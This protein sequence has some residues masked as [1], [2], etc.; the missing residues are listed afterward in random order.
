MNHHRRQS[1]FTWRPHGNVPLWKWSSDSTRALCPPG[2][3]WQ[4]GNQPCSKAAA[5]PDCSSSGRPTKRQGSSRGHAES[6][7]RG[8][9]LFLRPCRLC[10]AACPL[11]RSA[12]GT[13]IPRTP[14]EHPTLSSRDAQPRSPFPTLGSCKAPL[15]GAEPRPAPF[16]IYGLGLGFYFFFFLSPFPSSSP[17][18]LASFPRAAPGGGRKGG[19]GDGAASRGDAV[20]PRDPPRPAWSPPGHGEYRGTPRCPPPRGDALFHAA[21]PGRAVPIAR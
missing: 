17:A 5:F 18:L 12:R 16:Y 8:A 6:G 10:R 19:G 14:P 2:D 1:F 4:R 13:S 9:L 15:E 21:G 20:A 3:A 7:C 11:C